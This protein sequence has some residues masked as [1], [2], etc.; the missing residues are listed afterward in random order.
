[1]NGQIV[2]AEQLRDY[3]QEQLV[4]ILLLQDPPTT[5]GDITELNHLLYRTIACGGEKPGAAIVVANPALRIMTVMDHT[6]K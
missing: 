5:G 4:D 2:V 1:M 3:C 6:S